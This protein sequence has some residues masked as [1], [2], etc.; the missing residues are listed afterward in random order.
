MDAVALSI[1]FA[2]GGLATLNPCGFPLLGS[3]LSFYVGAEAASLPR[4]P[5]RI[6]QGL[7]VGAL[8]T[9]GF[10]GVFTVVGLPITLGATAVTRAVPWAGIAVGLAL[11]GVGI[12]GLSGRQIAVTVPHAPCPGHQR[13]A[14]AMLVF[15]VAY[16]SASLGCT[17]PVFLT[18]V[19][20]SLGGATTTTSVT[21]F[22]AY[23]AGIAVVLMALSVAA[24]LVHDGLARALRRVLP[25]MPRIT[26]GLLSG[27]GLYLT[28]YWIRVRFG[29]KA[30]LATDP[31][32]GPV[33]AFTARLGAQAEGQGFRLV[34]LAGVAV[35][36][37]A[38]LA[39]W[40][41]RHRAG[42]R[43]VPASSGRETS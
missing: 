16:G 35:A 23:G 6:A 4:A 13:R 9:A 43:P 36:A 1:A 19:G 40:Q 18:L 15:G 3:F 8:V 28:Y 31:I 39:W 33:T 42:K 29:P 11:L 37:A 38:L 7:V 41:L 27:A 5:T 20:A 25:Y 32:V 24:A 30:T 10:L 22:V 26:G 21:A 17:L 12:V 14:T 2:A 34:L